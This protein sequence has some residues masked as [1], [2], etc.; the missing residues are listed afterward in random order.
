MAAQP[1]AQPQ[2]APSP[3]QR[4]AML[5]QW[6][7]ASHAQLRTYQWIETTVVS[8]DGEEKSRKQS[9]NYYGVDGQ[10]QKVPLASAEQEKSGGPPGVLPIGRLAK[11]AAERKKKELQEYMQQAGALIHSYIPPDPNRIQQTVDQGG[12]SINM[13]QPGR[14]TRI[15]LRNYL[16]Q[17][18]L[19]SFDI[20]VP[21]NRLTGM[22]VSSYL[23][24]PDDAIQMQTMMGLLP[25][26]TIF[27]EKTTLNAPAEK[28]N[29]VVENTGH[30]HN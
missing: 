17:G 2:A 25:D 30:R 16:K 29:V 14:L 4:V 13:V 28:L 21:T 12:L 8:M 15:E 24:S 3:Q 1:A 7:Q 11:R 18:D 26:G 20:E 9:N 19:L 6:L 5:K 23:D 27:T 22:A 10:L